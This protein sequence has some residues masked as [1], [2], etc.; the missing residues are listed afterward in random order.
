MSTP[1]SPRQGL[2]G[3][4]ASKAKSA[5]QQ[6][7]SN[8]SHHRITLTWPFQNAC[9]VTASAWLNMPAVVSDGS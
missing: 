8:R 2:A 9:E 4:P 1:N 5:G 6:Q 7:T 3:D